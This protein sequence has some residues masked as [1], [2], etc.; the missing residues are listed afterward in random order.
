MIEIQVG[1]VARQRLRLDQPRVRILGGIAGDGAGLGDGLAHGRGPQVRGARRSLALAEVHRDPE[2]AITLVLDRVDL[3]QPHAHRQPL[4][5]RGVR[6]AVRGALAIRLLE[7]ERG[8]LGE[9]P[10]RVSAGGVGLR[11]NCVHRWAK[12]GSRV[13]S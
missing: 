2:S 3:A 13:V 7:G 10:A 1:D 12:L 9:L 11:G 4:A 6:L 5:H 8:D